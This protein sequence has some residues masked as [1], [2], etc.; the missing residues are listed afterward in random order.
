MT[1][2]QA[3]GSSK[4][5]IVDIT[6][7]EEAIRAAEDAL[8]N[9]HS[10]IEIDGIDALEKAKEAQGKYG[11]ESTHMTEIAKEARALAERSVSLGRAS[12]SVAILD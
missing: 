12:Y 7:A 10:H 6:A 2:Q 4:K 11:Q 1:T 9:A 8:R 5:S 3:D